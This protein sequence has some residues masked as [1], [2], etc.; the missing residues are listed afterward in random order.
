MYIKLVKNKY[1]QL[2]IYQTVYPSVLLKAIRA[3][4]IYAQKTVSI[5]VCTYFCLL[6]PELVPRGEKFLP[7][8]WGAE[9]EKCNL[10][11]HV[12]RPTVVN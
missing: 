10:A 8:G 12:H 7:D 3:R 1:R 11:I 9:G 4:F 6:Y 2:H 5:Y